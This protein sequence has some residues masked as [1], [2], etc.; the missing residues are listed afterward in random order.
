MTKVVGVLIILDTVLTYLGVS[1]GIVEANPVAR[2][3]GF[4][5]FLFLK[6][7]SGV[8]ILL[9][10]LDKYPHNFHKYWLGTLALI[11]IFAI[12]WNAKLILDFGIWPVT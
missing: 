9:L 6:L 4:A 5:L 1:M 8:A 12:L 3:M 11:L 7:V 10:D 2:S